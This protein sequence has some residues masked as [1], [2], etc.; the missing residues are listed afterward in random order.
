M[1]SPG[2]PSVSG[3]DRGPY[4]DGCLSTGGK[5]IGYCQTCKIRKCC[6]DKGLENCAACDAPPETN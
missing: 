6:R 4:G 2:S 1:P 5:H 3:A